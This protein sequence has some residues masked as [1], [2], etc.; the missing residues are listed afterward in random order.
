MYLI[1]NTYTATFNA[2]YVCRG[3]IPGRAMAPPDFGRSVNPISTSGDRLCLPNYYL[4]PRIFSPSDGPGPNDT[5]TAKSIGI[6]Y[7]NLS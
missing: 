5:I 4:H 7:K 1:Q 3:V 2:M 6:L